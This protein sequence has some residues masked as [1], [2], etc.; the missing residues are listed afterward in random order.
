MTSTEEDL[1]RQINAATFDTDGLPVV[2]L[3]VR[4]DN[5][6]EY[7]CSPD[8]RDIQ[9]A[10]VAL[11]PASTSSTRTIRAMAWSALTRNGVLALGWADFDRD[12]P[13]VVPVAVSSVDPTGTATAD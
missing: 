5:G 7:R 8:Q 2:E 13:W 1:V 4:F 6:D 9:R 11:G 12:V 3:R 10:E